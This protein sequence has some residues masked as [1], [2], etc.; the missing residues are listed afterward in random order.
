MMLEGNSLAV[1]V[2]ENPFRSRIW[3]LSHCNYNELD[4]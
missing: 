4:C 3:R 1:G 2:F